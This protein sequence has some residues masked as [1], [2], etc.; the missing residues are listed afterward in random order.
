[1]KIKMNKMKTINFLTINSKYR[2][3]T[4]N[5]MNKKHVEYVYQT[6]N[7]NLTHFSVLLAIVLDHVQ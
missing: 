4:K 1:M 6:N 2:Y 7:P 3:K 5:I